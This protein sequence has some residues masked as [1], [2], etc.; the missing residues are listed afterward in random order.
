[1]EDSLFPFHK[2]Y[3][4]FFKTPESLAKS[5]TKVS[6]R[7]LCTTGEV[8]FLTQTLRQKYE[9]ALADYKAGR[10]PNRFGL[11]RGERMN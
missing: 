7:K 9:R 6:G 4:G 8:A 2:V 5:L 1:M 10:R 11:M 3:K